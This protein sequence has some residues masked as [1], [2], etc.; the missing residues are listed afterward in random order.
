[1]HTLRITQYAA[2]ENQYKVE[3]ALEGGPFRQ[4]AVSE[5]KFA[6]SPQDEEGIRWYL[7]DFPLFRHDPT[8]VIAARVEKR[9]AEIGR[10]LFRR[11]FQSGDDARDIWADFRRE[12]NSARVEFAAGVREA[13]AI[14]WELIRDPKTDTCLA[15]HA[16]AFV[17]SNSSPARPYRPVE[18][19]K[20]PIRTLLV[21][22]R[23]GG[24]NDVPFRSV[25]SMLIKGLSD[26]DRDLFRLDV[27]RP[28]T[29]DALAKRL[30]AAKN[31][32]EPYHVVHFDGHGAF[33]D[34]EEVVEAMRK[35]GEN[36]DK[37]LRRMLAE[38]GIGDAH[39]F[40]VAATVYP[41]RLKGG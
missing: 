29:F 5:F 8:P 20:G 36:R 22:C 21:I 16:A 3:I 24:R 41:K 35:K 10:D 7:E 6:L 4:T 25:A 39:R 30:R 27:L 19:G 26:A 14:P 37:A 31:A 15:L 17:R 40:D 32:G 38:I 11:V 9:M 23:P 18:S 28:A 34:M 12:A 13:T 2:E 33:V 1:M